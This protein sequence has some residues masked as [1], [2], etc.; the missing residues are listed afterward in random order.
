MERPG[1]ILNAQREATCVHTMPHRWHLPSEPLQSC[2]PL[3]AVLRSSADKPQ[4]GPHLLLQ[5]VVPSWPPHEGNMGPKADTLNLGVPK[6]SFSE[7][8]RVK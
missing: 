5:E 7:L 4:P 8:L 2:L 3:P 6:P 1:T